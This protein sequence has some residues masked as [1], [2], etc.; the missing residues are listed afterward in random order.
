[1][2]SDACSAASVSG[3]QRHFDD[4]TVGH[5]CT[6]RDFDGQ[7]HGSIATR[8]GSNNLP[9]KRGL[10]LFWLRDLG[11]CDEARNHRALNRALDNASHALL[12]VLEVRIE[13]NVLRV[14]HAAVHGAHRHAALEHQLL[15]H[16]IAHQFDKQARL[17]RLANDGKFHGLV[18]ASGPPRYLDELS[19]VPFTCIGG[20]WCFK[21]I[22]LPIFCQ[23]EV[24]NASITG[25]LYSTIRIYFVINH[26][27][28]DMYA[29]I[30]YTMLQ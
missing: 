1:M 24:R 6:T 12:G 3:W 4:V 26:D 17:Q 21:Y 29:D 25:V 30:S 11:V 10:G 15:V 22:A 7:I 23:Y 2:N 14:A 20:E 13:V 19:E 5:A 27:N 28:S 16:R 9:A 8:L 18:H